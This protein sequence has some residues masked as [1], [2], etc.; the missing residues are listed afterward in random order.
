MNSV[1][2]ILNEKL[3]E[4]QQKNPRLSYRYFAQK[5][6][7]SS[8]A[9]SEI[10]SGKRKISAKMAK[11]IADRLH[12]TPSDA[13]AFMGR[14]LEEDSPDLN[15]IQMRD[16]QFHLISDWQHFA[17]LNL[18]KS[19]RCQHRASW[20]ASQLNLSVTA[21]QEALDRLLRLE[22]LKLEKKK[23]VRTQTRLTTSDDIM[24]VSIQKS[25]FQDLEMMREHLSTLAV[26]ER[27]LTSLTFLLDPAR[28]A[29]FKKQIRKMQDQFS[30]KFESTKS[31]SVFRL[32]VALFPLKNP[33]K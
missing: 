8:G 9:L 21:A 23:Y 26:G 6:G 4:L 16:D 2:I 25:N 13:K 1:Q 7:I 27:D 18:V 24:N 17:I 31:V 33:K 5:L 30:E 14:P 29:E 22:M 15:Y 28:M 12:L 11:K 3:L 20:F 10:L 19:E 32:T